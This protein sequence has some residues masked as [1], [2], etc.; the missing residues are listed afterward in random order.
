[1]YA[2]SGMRGAQGIYGACRLRHAA[3][4]GI[5][6]RV[7]VPEQETPTDQQGNRIGTAG[8]SV[9]GKSLAWLDL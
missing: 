4:W 6:R 5:P 1:M 7:C 3:G 9:T 2:C 8:E